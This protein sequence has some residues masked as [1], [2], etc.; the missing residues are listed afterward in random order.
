[1]QLLLSKPPVICRQLVPRK[2]QLAVTE[3]IFGVPF[4]LEMIARGFVMTMTCDYRVSGW[5]F[6]LMDNGGCYVSRVFRNACQEHEVRH[7]RTR[8]Y[9]PQTNGKAERFIQTLIRE[10]AYKR[11]YRTSNQRSK[12]LEP[13]LRYYNRERPHSALTG[14]APYERIRSSR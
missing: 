9:R 3:E 8:P 4:R 7:L 10:W 13:W 5:Q 2:D 1:M 12:Q 11:P 6:F 14:N